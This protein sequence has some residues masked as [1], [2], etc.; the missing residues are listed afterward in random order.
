MLLSRR[1]IGAFVMRSWANS[2]EVGY[3][4]FDW[5]ILRSFSVD[6]GSSWIALPLLGMATEPRRT[7]SNLA[8][9]CSTDAA[10][11]QA[12]GLRA[13]NWAVR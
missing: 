12:P 5:V 13:A 11:M 2:C 1:P 7:S 10:K 4:V 8:P 9:S 6:F 3:S